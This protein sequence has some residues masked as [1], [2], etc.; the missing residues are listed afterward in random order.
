MKRR[1]KMPQD[2]HPD[3]VE[4]LT[5][6]VLSSEFSGARDLICTIQVDPATANQMKIDGLATEMSLAWH[7]VQE[8]LKEANKKIDVTSLTMVT[9]VNAFNGTPVVEYRFYGK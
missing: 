8:F 4:E 5:N 9:G 2:Q 3:P 1:S 6:K 7:D